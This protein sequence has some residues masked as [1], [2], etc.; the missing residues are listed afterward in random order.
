MYTTRDGAVRQEAFSTLLQGV[1]LLYEPPMRRQA[2]GATRALHTCAHMRTQAHTGAH[3]RMCK[4]GRE[5]YA[6]SRTQCA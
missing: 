1:Y 4:I 5:S 3:R 6:V 2:R